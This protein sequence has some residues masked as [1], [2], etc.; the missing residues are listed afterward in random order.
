MVYTSDPLGKIAPERLEL[1]RFVQPDVIRK[2]HVP[3]MDKGEELVVLHHSLEEGRHIIL[4]FNPTG[5]T[6]T[7]YYDFKEL[8]EIDS[9]YTQQWNSGKISAQKEKYAAGRI[10]AHDCLLIFGDENRPVNETIKNLW[11]W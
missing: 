1:F 11:K 3:F 10:P 7:A 6:L 5:K 9:M 2:P 4:L 8:A